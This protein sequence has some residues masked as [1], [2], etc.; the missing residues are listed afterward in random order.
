[1]SKP[2]RDFECRVYKT[3]RKL[4]GQII[5]TYAVLVWYEKGIEHRET[6]SIAAGENEDIVSEDMR[7]KKQAELDHKKEVMQYWSFTKNLRGWIEYRKNSITSTTYAGYRHR[8]EHVYDYFEVKY[9]DACLETLTPK[10]LT[11][12]FQYLLTNGNKRTGE[13][14]SRNTVNDVRK[15]LIAYFDDAVSLR[16]V[17]FL[18]D[19]RNMKVPR[20]IDQTVEEQP[21]MNADQVRVFLATCKEDEYWGKLHL[22]FTLYFISGMRRSEALAITWDRINFNED[23]IYVDRALVRANKDIY[24]NSKTKT[25]ES[26]RTYPILKGI[27]DE[28]MGARDEQIALGIYEEDGFVFKN[29][30][31][32]EVYDPDYISKTFKKI[33]K[34]C[35]FDNRLHLHSTRHSCVCILAEQG[36]DLEFI[37][38]WVGHAEDSK[39]TRKVYMHVIGDI[40]KKQAAVANESFMNIL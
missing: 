20:R 22:L 34:A 5:A 36:R 14:L 21:Y 2:V 17:R 32:G 9:P 13:G 39:M 10:M 25:R 37:Q 7:R 18:F 27:R 31:T 26:T 35:G 40:R 24:L 3:H 29:P 19:Y 33:I 8:A 28:L 23:T 1:M 16:G 30:D 38:N 4:N 11:D 6:H 12:F 15:M